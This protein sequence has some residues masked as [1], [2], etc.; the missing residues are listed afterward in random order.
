MYIQDLTMVIGDHTFTVYRITTQF[1]QFSGN[2]F[3][4]QRD[5]FYRQ[6]KFTHYLNLLGGISDT[7]KA[8]CNGS[9]DFF[10]GQRCAA[11][12]D[13]LHMR[14]DLVCTVNINIEFGHFIQ[15]N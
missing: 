8:F 13:H 12:F 6:W 4:G 14:I 11:T 7:D 3:A 10:T 5:H 15:I 9:D 1:T 2:I